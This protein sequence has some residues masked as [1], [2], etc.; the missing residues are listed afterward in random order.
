MKIINI[1]YKNIGN[2]YFVIENDNNGLLNKKLKFNNGYYLLLNMDARKRIFVRVQL[3]GTVGIS[4]AYE[5]LS[6]EPEDIKYVD[7]C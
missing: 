2:T 7:I 3:N 5:L 4:G 6:L 1:G